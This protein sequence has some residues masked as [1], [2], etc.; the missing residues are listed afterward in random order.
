MGELVSKRGLD[1]FRNYLMKSREPPGLLIKVPECTSPLLL[2]LSSCWAL[3]VPIRSQYDGLLQ[4]KK[5][6]ETKV[7]NANEGI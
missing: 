1:V 3:Y 5:Y 6:Q 2:R 7:S 4:R